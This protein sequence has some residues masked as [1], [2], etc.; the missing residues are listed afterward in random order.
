MSIITVIFIVVEIPRIYIGLRGILYSAIPSLSTFLLLTIFP[1]YFIVIYLGSYQE[2]IFPCDN[3]LSGLM[4]SFLSLEVL[5]GVVTLRELIYWK[6]SNFMKL[7]S[8]QQ[9]GNEEIDG[10]RAELL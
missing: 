5:L 4:L 2:F 1:Q 6:K 7:F 3:A 9:Y 8:T 10:E